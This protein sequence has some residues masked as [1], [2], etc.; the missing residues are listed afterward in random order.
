M[1]RRDWTII[2]GFVGTVLTILVVFLAGM[3]T[4]NSRFDTVYSRFDA[5]ENRLLSIEEHLRVP[6][7][8]QGEN[9][10]KPG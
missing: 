10:S 7:S 5:V 2:I 4:M 6:A 8:Y 9:A 1:E 3:Q